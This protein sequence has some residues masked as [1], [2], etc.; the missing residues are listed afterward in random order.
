MVPTGAQGARGKAGDWLIRALEI[1]RDSTTD[2]V[3]ER[4]TRPKYDDA[5]AIAIDTLDGRIAA[6][7]AKPKSTLGNLQT[8]ELLVEVRTEMQTAFDERWNNRQAPGA[9]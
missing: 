4:V 1:L 5:V 8:I 9:D 3:V 2:V 6:L 7:R